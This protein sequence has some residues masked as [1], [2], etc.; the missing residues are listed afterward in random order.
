MAE[1][2]PTASSEIAETVEKLTDVDPAAAMRLVDT[3]RDFLF[4]SVLTV[5]TALQLGAIVAG[6]AI[7]LFAARPLRRRLIGLVTHKVHGYHLKR[8]G[9]SVAELLLPI[10]WLVLLWLALAGLGALGRETTLIGIAATLISAWIVIRLVS[11]LVPSPFWAR[12]GAIA[13][14]TIAALSVV[15]W[16]GPAVNLLDRIGFPIGETRLSAC[17]SS[18]AW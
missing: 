6:A 7:A 3:A 15:G 11:V 14:W 1:A 8:F 10:V 9:A 4:G 12:V 17:S 18:R 13:A 2:Q 16:L 5:A